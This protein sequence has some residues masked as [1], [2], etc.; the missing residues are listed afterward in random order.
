MGQV[1]VVAIGGGVI[2][3]EL[4]IGRPEMGQ[5]F[6][7]LVRMYLQWLWSL[8]TL[9]CGLLYILHL[10]AGIVRDECII[11]YGMVIKNS[12]FE[13]IVGVDIDSRLG[14]VCLSGQVMI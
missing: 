8:A 2:T 12:L 9:G 3:S 5:V 6:L 13:S 1:S 4:V 10:D 7:Y 11:W 14:I